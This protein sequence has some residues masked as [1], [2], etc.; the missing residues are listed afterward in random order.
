MSEEKK[1]EESQEE[2]IPKVEQTVAE[3]KAV[4]ARE[5]PIPIAIRLPAGTVGTIN[6][7]P[8]TEDM[9]VHHHPNV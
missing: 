9:E 7:K 4:S 5:E 3:A 8:Q 6:D 2:L 1:I